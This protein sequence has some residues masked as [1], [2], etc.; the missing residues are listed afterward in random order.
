MYVS[1]FIGTAL[2]VF[3]GLSVV[4][5]LW[6][7]K[8]PLYDLPVSITIKR[9]LTGI[10]FGSTGAAIAFSRIGKVSGAHINP[11]V[12][13]AF[14]LERKIKWRDAMMYIVAQLAGGVLGATGLSIWGGIGSA[15]HYGASLPKAGV[16]IWQPLCGEIMCG[17]L[18]V[19][20]I[21]VMAS[22][23][24]T[25]KFTPLINP[26]LFAFLNVFESSWS[27]A[28]AN[29]ARSFGPALV[30]DIWHGQWI[31]FVGPCLGAGL[32]V[33]IVRSGIIGRHRPAEARLYH[34]DRRLHDVLLNI[35]QPLL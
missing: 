2:L 34:F 24:T 15:D 17:F 8:S 23:K 18:L 14:W 11:A 16:A 9:I 13:V 29:P 25:Q 31:Y 6:S 20:L 5:A 28:S 21:F 7:Q 30:A 3:I 12:T 32:A 33:V 1:E 22:H 10:L 4:I 27:G 35:P 19:A 26:P